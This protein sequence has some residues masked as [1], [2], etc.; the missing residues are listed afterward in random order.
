M[1]ATGLLPDTR[2]HMPCHSAKHLLSHAPHSAMHQ[3]WL[4]YHT[5]RCR[6]GCY[7]ARNCPEL[8]QVVLFD[9]VQ[10]VDSLPGNLA[11]REKGGLV[12]H[13]MHNKK[14][15]ETQLACSL[16]KPMSIET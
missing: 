2:I 7:I 14:Y 9:L 3:M 4:S 6:L 15:G 12:W 8:G 16:N 11:H 13:P 1:L 5:P 10:P